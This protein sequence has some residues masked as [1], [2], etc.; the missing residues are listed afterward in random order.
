MLDEK[1]RAVGGRIHFAGLTIA[2]VEVLRP[3]RRGTPAP[4]ELEWEG[5][6][7]VELPRAAVEPF[8]GELGK[9]DD[10]PF[11]VRF[12]GLCRRVL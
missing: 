2:R 4:P 8:V 3:Q 10:L 12:V 7:V 6:F 5:T 9:T 11:E 1:S